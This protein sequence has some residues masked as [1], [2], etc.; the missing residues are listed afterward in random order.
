MCYLKKTNKQ[1][2]IKHTYTETLAP[3]SSK[4]K[5]LQP[6]GQVFYENVLTNRS[7]K[8]VDLQQWIWFLAEGIA[9]M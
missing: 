5:F 7:R 1:T 6:G 8:I 9:Y 4:C 2:K 3:H